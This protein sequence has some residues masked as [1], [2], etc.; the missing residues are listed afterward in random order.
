ML[1]PRNGHRKHSTLLLLAPLALLLV[2]ALIAFP[3][4]YAQRLSGLGTTAAGTRA[5][6]PP[7]GIGVTRAADGESI[8]ISDGTFAFDTARP[9]GAL[10]IQ[11]A[12]A[13]KHNN[14]NTAIAL[15]NQA[16]AQDTNDAEAL[17]Y[18]ED[19]RVLNSG[20]PYVTFVVGTMITGSSEL[21]GV[22]RS[23]FQGAYLGQKESNDGSKLSGGVLVRLLT[24]NSGSNT[25]DATFVA[26]Q[27]VQ[28]ARTDPHFVGVCGWS[29][30][31]RNV[32]VVKVLGP[33]HIPMVSSKASS[34][35]FTNVSPYFFRTTPANIIQAYA[36]AKYAEQTLK[37]TRVAMFYD[38]NDPY[39]QNLAADFD[40]QF[41]ADGN[42]VVAQETYTIYHPETLPARLQDALTHHPDLIYFS[43]YSND[44]STILIN[45]PPGNLPI[46]GG[47][48]LYELGG[49][50]S[51]ARANFSRLHF[52]TYFYPDEWDIL[53]YGNL[54]PAFFA[55]YADTYDP[56][57]THQGNPYGFTRADFNVAL[58]YDAMLALLKGCDIAL[59]GSQ[60]SITP[61]DLQRGLTKVNGANAFQGVSGQIAFGSDGNP[62][63]KA[64]VILYVDPEGHVKMEPIRVGRFLM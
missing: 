38:P 5:S 7:N 39:S 3:L 30:S 23:V 37:A 53:G 59:V 40:K 6:I 47:D 27:V 10:K 1:K 21:V 48:A 35:C 24:A 34:D 61:Q 11:A 19:L 13:L 63:D 25:D 32:K 54:K 43:G 58:T 9:D 22:G 26:Q 62:I 57:G 18:L 8:G 29:Y 49:Y 60:K 15:L 14:V 28:L 16:V 64:I 42:S 12:Q 31:S 36:G 4:F 46:M 17:I 41:E 44:V 50:P 33:A 52:T 45:L 51:I 55:E 20:R 2:L 56:N